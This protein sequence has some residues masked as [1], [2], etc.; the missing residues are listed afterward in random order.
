MRLSTLG[1]LVTLACGL[2]LCWTPRVATAQQPGKV[3]RLGF[4]S[5]WSPP[6]PSTPA[7]QQR[8][9]FFQPFWQEMRKLGWMSASPFPRPFSSGPTR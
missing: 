1:L 5:F 3:Y 9:P 2:G 6:S 4:L 7:G 8:S